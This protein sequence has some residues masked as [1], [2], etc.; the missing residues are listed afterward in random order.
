M[1]EKVHYITIHNFPFHM[2]LKLIFFISE[3]ILMTTTAPPFKRI[4]PCLGLQKLIILVYWV[5]F[6]Q[7]SS[8]LLEEKSSLTFSLRITSK[9]FHITS[10]NL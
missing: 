1:K 9:E 10:E 3:A 5:L 6:K 2:L 4:S 7:S 8:C